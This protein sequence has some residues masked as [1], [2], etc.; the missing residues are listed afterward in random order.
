[1]KVNNFSEGKKNAN[2]MYIPKPFG[3]KFTWRSDNL[4]AITE[5]ECKDKEVYIKKEI[6]TTNANLKLFWQ[7][8]EIGH[9]FAEWKKDSIINIWDVVIDESSR[10]QGLASLMVKIITRELLFRQKT[11]SFKIR[12]IRLFKPDEQEIKLQNVGMAV[13]AH[14]LGLDCQYELET[15]LSENNI[16]EVGLILPTE[17]TPPA[18]SLTLNIF[19]YNLVALIINLDTDKPINDYDFYVR[20]R[21]Q[22]EIFADWVKKGVMV[23]GNADYLLRDEGIREFVNH[24]AMSV[25]EAEL[26]YSKIK[27]IK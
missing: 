22:F 15:L 14:K 2:T 12:M 27:G 6:D 21:T 7:E 16:K 18:Y 10:C 20:F 25:P 17:T 26:F 4:I 3:P 9:C 24:L 11:T 19:P 5:G 1:M 8:K 13:I 23:V